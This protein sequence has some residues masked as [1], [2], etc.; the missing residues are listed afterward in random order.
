VNLDFKKSFARDLKKRKSE[1]SLLEQVRQVIQQVEKARDINMI[2]NLKK[3][4][5]QGNYYCIRIGDYRLGLVIEHDTV[6]SGRHRN[7]PA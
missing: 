3:L 5:A 2:R 4:K 6:C 1:N 7:I